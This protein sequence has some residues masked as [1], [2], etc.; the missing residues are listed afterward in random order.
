MVNVL[1]CGIN[2]DMGKCMYDVAEHNG[3]NVVCGVDKSLGTTF[4]CPVYKSF[5]EVREIIDFVIDVSS[6]DMLEDVLAF[7]KENDYPLIEG[8]VGYSAKQKQQLKEAGDSVPV[9]MSYNLSL[10]VNLLFRLCVETA[11]AL[12]NYDIEIIEKYNANKVNAPGATT[13]NLANELN[14]ALGATRKIVYGRTSQRKKGEAS[15]ICRNKGESSMK[16]A[17][18]AILV[19]L[20][21]AAF[22][23]T[24]ACE[25]AAICSANCGFC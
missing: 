11:K 1:I 16:R 14:E 20:A 4:N 7:V 15:T 12:K 5:D 25:E 10:G 8:S 24:A 23:S 19:L 17:M 18:A 9:F 22:V 3:I 13:I 21:L 2:T 6:P